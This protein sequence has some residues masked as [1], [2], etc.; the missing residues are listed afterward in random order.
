M[1]LTERHIIKKNHKDFNELDKITHL[2]KNLYNATLYA[3]RQH[4][5][6]SNQYLNYQTI[7]N[8]FVQNHNVDFYSLPSKVSQQ[9]LKM[10]D[11]N[12]K[13]FFGALKSKR[14]GTNERVVKIPNYLI[15]SGNYITTYTNQAISF[16]TTGYIKLSGT[17]IL[18]KTE[19]KNI[20]Q[21]RVVPKGNHFIIDVIYTIPDKEKKENN[22]RYASIDLGLN[23]LAAIGSNVVAPKL[24]NGKPLKAINHFYNRKLSELKSNLE[25]KG[26]GKTSNKIKQITH[27]R[28]NKITDYLHKASRY[29][30]NQ[31]V[32]N[33]INT[34][35][36]GENK[37]W[38]QEIDM[39]KKNNQ[40]FVQVP[41][42]K[43][44]QMLQYKAEMEGINILKQEE[45]YTSKACFLTNDPIPVYGEDNESIKFSGYRA[46]R[47][48][49]K[50]KG[51]KKYMN[52]DVNGALNIL[53]KAVGNFNYDPIQ[54]C[55]T[56]SVF[57]VNFN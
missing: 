11:Q 57:T 50:I 24:I 52:A 6:N 43:F 33:Q 35:I 55:S 27:K 28:N 44:K 34:L 1:R 47:G 8:Q 22:G 29:I 13:S 32:A 15:K 4:F 48:L 38:K 23:N 51:Q 42:D 18:V 2:S 49:Y 56:P 14:K 10:V 16:K 31:L 17:D 54:V 30:I 40:N 19:K 9:T 41:F 7:A 45:S 26:Q 21:V 36:I 5:F 12:F 46:K 25:K 53:R 20:Q 37:E 39:S 3:I